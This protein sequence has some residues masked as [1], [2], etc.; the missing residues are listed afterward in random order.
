MNFKKDTFQ[1]GLLIDL[2]GT[3]LNKNDFISQKVI[4]DLK[5]LKDIIPIS[6]VTGRGPQDVFKFSNILDLYGPQYGEN[7]SSAIDGRSGKLIFQNLINY[8][9][10]ELILNEIS[11]SNFSYLVVSGGVTLLNSPGNLTNISSIVVSS[12]REEDL[13]LFNSKLGILQGT[14]SQKSIDENGNNFLNYHNE[15]SG[16]DKSLKHFIDFYNLYDE[17]TFV[18]G[19]GMNDISMIKSCKNSIAMGNASDDIKKHANFV[20]KSINEDGVSYA[21]KRFIYPSI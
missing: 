5:K 18:I 6:I 15:L 10:A 16:K 4:V 14:I 19:D 1:S 3:I 12:K 13:D 8:K 9:S 11:I 17:K 20:T 2:D 7:G 21:L